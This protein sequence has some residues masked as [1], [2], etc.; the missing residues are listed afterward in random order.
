MTDAPS[1][2]SVDRRRCAMRVA[3][4]RDE[5][6]RR[7]HG[8]VQFG[9]FIETRHVRVLVTRGAR[10]NV[11]R[12]TVS[13]YDGTT[14]PVSVEMHIEEADAAALAAIVRAASRLRWRARAVALF[15]RLTE[16]FQRKQA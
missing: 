7:L 9:T 14:A 16:P 4:V 11:L 3:A 8:T 1:D 6:A 5:L 2:S 13:R 15:L 10:P 12:L